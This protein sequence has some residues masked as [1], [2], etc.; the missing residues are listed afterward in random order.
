MTNTTYPVEYADNSHI[1]MTP[2]KE[3]AEKLH[4]LGF[5]FEDYEAEHKHTANSMWGADLKAEL[6]ALSA[7]A[8]E[9]TVE[10]ECLKCDGIYYEDLDVCPHCGNEDKQQTIYLQPEEEEV[11]M[12]EVMLDELANQIAEEAFEMV[13][14]G[15]PD[16]EAEDFICESVD[17][18]EWVIYYYKAHQVCQN[19]NT[20]QGADWMEQCGIKG[21]S[22]NDY[23]TKLA[24]GELYCRASN[25]LTLKLGELV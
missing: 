20:D 2:A 14:N 19:C 10:V 5:T 17:G 25:A 18:S 23:A 8:D 15:T 22:Y 9:Q 11:F 7:E 3:Y 21:D 12:N 13:K 1:W 24:Y 16:Y 4:N 6:I